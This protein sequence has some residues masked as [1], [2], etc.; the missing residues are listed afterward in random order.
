M[1]KNRPTD[2][3]R[4]ILQIAENRDKGS[5]SRPREVLTEAEVNNVV[6][7]SMNVSQLLAALTSKATTESPG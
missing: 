4:V 5:S 2:R 1:L 6:I 7:Y 3:R